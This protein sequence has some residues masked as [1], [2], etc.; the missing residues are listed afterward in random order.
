MAYPDA[1]RTLRALP[2]MM[3]C[4][5][6]RFQKVASD[7][8]ATDELPCK[9]GDG[10]FPVQYC[11]VPGRV[12]Y[13]SNKWLWCRKPMRNALSQS[14]LLQLQIQM[15]PRSVI[16]ERNDRYGLSFQLPA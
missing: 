2:G 12:P 9:L 8:R 11:D 16:A 13:R 4:V 7:R 6:P 14:Q 1:L 10:V 15:H 5:G 3:Q